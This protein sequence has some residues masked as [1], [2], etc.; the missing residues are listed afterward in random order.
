MFDNN[1]DGVITSCEVNKVFAKINKNLS[2]VPASKNGIEFSEFLKLMT[3]EKKEDDVE[4]LE[5]AFKLF[6]LDGTGKISRQELESALKNLGEDINDKNLN[7]ILETV[8]L[9]GDG[10]IS[11]EGKF[12]T[13]KVLVIF[14]KNS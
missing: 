4:E 1:Q 3:E 7:M 14:V 12:Y 6:D 11:F 5:A 13:L 10:K 9:D 2:D 8:D